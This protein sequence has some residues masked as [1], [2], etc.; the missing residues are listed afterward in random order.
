MESGE[1]LRK[2][3]ALRLR[4]RVDPATVS[5]DNHPPTAFVVMGHGNEETANKKIVPKGCIL[6]VQVHS[7]EVNYL[8]QDSETAIFNDPEKH[9]YLDPI[10]NYKYITDKINLA[11][12]SNKKYYTPLAVYI[13]GD[14]YPDFVYSLISYWDNDLA[15]NSSMPAGTF[16]LRYSGIA[17][18]PF[19]EGDPYA[20]V[21]GKDTEG[22]EKFLNLY[23]K[24]IY[25]PR[26]E[27]AQI[28]DEMPGNKTLNDIIYSPEVEKKIKIKQSE[29]FEALGKGVYYNLV[30][31]ATKSSLLVKHTNTGR[32][33]I[34]NNQRS[35]VNSSLHLRKDRPEILQAIGEAEG[36]RQGFI[37]KLNKNH[38]TNVQEEE[39]HIEK[40]IERIE[41]LKENPTELNLSMIRQLQNKYYTLLKQYYLDEIPQYED[42]VFI[43]KIAKFMHSEN[44]AQKQM[45]S[46]IKFIR[47]KL[48]ELEKAKY[49][50]VTPKVINLEHELVLQEQMAKQRAAHAIAVNR[51]AQNNAN[52]EN[53][54]RYIAQ[55][56]PISNK[57]GGKRTRVVKNYK[58]KTRRKSRR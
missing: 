45:E 56:K 54:A 31:R 52:F 38:A 33:A 57:S 48:D 51:A 32:N 50:P 14:E 44:A 23:K 3:N 34:N 46:S 11:R 30:C 10:A 5:G 19:P 29:L 25:P 20:E 21:I 42:P 2:V 16:L 15:D 40:I 22:K 24:S 39:I 35:L 17:Q 53:A 4:K 41:H 13:E 9:R 1:R 7:G 37:G 55:E 18:Y 43:K 36:Q 28:I 27:I 6:V 26:G 58:N 49:G 8:K 47:D 12:T